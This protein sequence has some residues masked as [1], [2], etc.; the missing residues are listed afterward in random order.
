[1]TRALEIGPQTVRWQNT[2]YIQELISHWYCPGAEVGKRA[3]EC[4]PS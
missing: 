3:D 2:V 1:M 4:W